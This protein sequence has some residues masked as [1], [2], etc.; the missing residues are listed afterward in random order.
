[1]GQVFE[2]F[3]GFRYGRQTQFES[4]QTKLW[5]GVEKH[6]CGMTLRVQE[7][8][9]PSGTPFGRF[10]MACMLTLHSMGV[11]ADVFLQC[12]TIAMGGNAGYSPR[13]AA[14]GRS[15][16]FKNPFTP[17]ADASSL[18]TPPPPGHGGWPSPA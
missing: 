6:V 7:P 10:L 17:L 13:H 3:C 4:G 8:S 16:P 9:G 11:K 18:A 12:L 2:G 1:M 5:G 15:D 14:S